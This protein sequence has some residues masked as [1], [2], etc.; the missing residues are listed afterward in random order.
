MTRISFATKKSFDTS[1]GRQKWNLGGIEQFERQQLHDRL[2]RDFARAQNMELIEIPYSYQTLQTRI[3]F[4]ILGDRDLFS[5][6]V[7][8]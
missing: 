3:Y 7:N 2:K 1:K 6:K 8:K 4:Y 5:G